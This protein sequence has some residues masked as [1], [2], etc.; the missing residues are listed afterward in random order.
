[1]TKTRGEWLCTED[2][3]LYERQVETCGRVGYTTEK[4][5]SEKTIQTS[6]RARKVQTKTASEH[7]S[8][9]NVDEFGSSKTGSDSSE[10]SP[11][12]SSP[13]FKRS[14]SSTTA[15][16]SLVRKKHLSTNKAH[17]VLQTLSEEGIG[18][19]VPSQSGVWRRVVRESKLMID[20]YRNLLGDD[21]FVF[22]SMVSE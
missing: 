18:V 3:R 19:P 8:D 17:K 14:W 6:K 13:D 11:S 16:S 7:Q 5:A 2:K 4:S 1:M 12:S 15:A 10:P 21:N 22:I 20:K 9:V